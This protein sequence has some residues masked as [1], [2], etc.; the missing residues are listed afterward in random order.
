MSTADGMWLWSDDSEEEFGR[1]PTPQRKRTSK[2]PVVRQ[3]AR[4]A[5]RKSAGKGKKRGK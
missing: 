4:R 3:R 1:R 2:K 5:K